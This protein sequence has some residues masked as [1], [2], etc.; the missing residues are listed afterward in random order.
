MDTTKLYLIQSYNNSPVGQKLSYNASQ[1]FGPGVPGG[2]PTAS[3]I[4]P[5]GTTPYTYEWNF[6]VDHTLKNWL[7]EVSYLGSAAHHYEER[8]NLDPQ[9]AD[10]SF[11]LPG[12]NG[13]QENSQSG[14]SFYSGLVVRT[15]KRFNSG[16]Y[17]S[18]SYTLSKCL[19]WPWQDVFSWHPLDM[20][21]DRGHCQEDLSH[22][23]VANTIYEL[24][25][26]Q[27]KMFLNEGGLLNQVVGGWKL[28]AI[29]ALH[30][31]P[32]AT[33]GSNQSLGI[34]VNGL[35]DVSG[36]VNN[37]ALNGG[38]GKHGKLGPYFNT[39]NVH[40]VTAVGTQGNSSVQSVYGPG[41]ADWDLSGDKTWKYADRYGLTF[42]A[43]VFNA[44]NRVNF[45]GLDTGVNDTRFGYVQAAGP[46]RQ[47]QLSLRVSF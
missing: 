21:L 4:Q 13:V 39:Q 36:P 19:G 25:F 23:L 44:F 41:Y 15:E 8:P 12:W 1:L 3:F 5:N 18:G 2:G 47:I 11:P 29:A 6:A 31:G 46:A 20:R 22:N 24:P 14:S 34:F 40:A 26:G 38:L 43:D 30:S 7:M 37:S 45:N 16:F 35:P 42:R 28:V 33:L 10:G 27:G 17:L 32:W 9:N